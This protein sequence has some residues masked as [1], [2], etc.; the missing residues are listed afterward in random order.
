MI[1]IDCIDHESV[2]IDDTLFS[3]IDLSVIFTDLE[4]TS[5]YQE[6]IMNTEFMQTIKFLT[7][8]LQ[9]RVEGSN[10]FHLKKN[11]KKSYLFVKTRFK[12]FL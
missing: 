5:V 12:F 7:T 9:L 11:V 8:E 10:N 3:V 1:S 4:D 2:E 6:T